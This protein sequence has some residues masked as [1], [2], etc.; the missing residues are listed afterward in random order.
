MEWGDV[1]LGL[2]ECLRGESCVCFFCFY[3]FGERRDMQQYITCC[4]CVCVCVL[5]GVCVCT[6]WCVCVCVERG[7]ERKRARDV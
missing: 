4:F 6:E 2:W 5:S 7:R 3:W 1:E